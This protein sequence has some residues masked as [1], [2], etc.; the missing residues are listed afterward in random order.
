MHIFALDLDEIAAVRTKGFD[1]P[2]VIIEHF[3]VLIKVADREIS[4]FDDAAIG[5]QP[6]EHQFEQC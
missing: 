4:L 1:K 5:L 6:S 3:A 2:F